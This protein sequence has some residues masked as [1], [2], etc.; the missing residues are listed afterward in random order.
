MHKEARIAQIIGEIQWGMANNRDK[1]RQKM[2][3]IGI[4]RNLL[5]LNA[6]TLIPEITVSAQ[7]LL[8]ELKDW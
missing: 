1:H 7:M 6:Q 5:V 8:K 2:E 4:I 3:P